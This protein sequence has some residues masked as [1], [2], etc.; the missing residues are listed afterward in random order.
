[1]QQFLWKLYTSVTC[2]LE[3]KQFHLYSSFCLSSK[4]SSRRCMSFLMDDINYVMLSST[5]ICQNTNLAV[6]TSYTHVKNGHVNR[7]RPYLDLDGYPKRCNGYCVYINWRSWVNPKNKIKLVFT[8]S[9]TLLS[10]QQQGI[11]K[12]GAQVSLY[13]SPDINKSS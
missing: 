6:C 11:K 13:H 8:T 5:T 9:D 2:P 7:T 3:R 10:T 1:M 12:L 4:E